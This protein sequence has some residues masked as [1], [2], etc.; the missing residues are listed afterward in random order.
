MFDKGQDSVKIQESVHQ[1]WGQ[2][3][4]HLYGYGFYFYNQSEKTEKL[5]PKD[6]HPMSS[7]LL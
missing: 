3:Q 6:K 4:N 5:Y 2:G 7:V 1:A